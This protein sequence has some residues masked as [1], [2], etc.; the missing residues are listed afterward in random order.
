MMIGH[1]EGQ[2]LKGWRKYIIR[3]FCKFQ[4]TMMTIQSYMHLG[5]H[6]VTDDEVNY[7]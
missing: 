5:H 1:V 6:Y 3:G 7:Y 4:I 2:P